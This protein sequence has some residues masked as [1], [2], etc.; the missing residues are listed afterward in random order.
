MAVSFSL[1][2][3]VKCAWPRLERNCLRARSPRVVRVSLEEDDFPRSL[4]LSLP[5]GRARA[6]SLEVCGGCSRDVLV[7]LGPRR[8]VGRL[9]R[10]S[11]QTRVREE[12]PARAGEVA[13]LFHPRLGAASRRQAAIEHFSWVF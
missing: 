3:K 10:S 8:Q 11:I 4:S 1:L 9:H 7:F 5:L 13:R 2:G 6:R 12:L